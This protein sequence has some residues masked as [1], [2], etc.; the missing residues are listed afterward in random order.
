M[1]IRDDPRVL[2][3]INPLYGVA[4]LLDHGQYRAG[5]AR[6]RVSGA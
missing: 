6:R 5:D 4:F 3:A 2:L 1:H